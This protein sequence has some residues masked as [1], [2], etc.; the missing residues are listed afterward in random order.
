M[1]SS[2]A[3]CVDSQPARVFETIQQRDDVGGRGRLRIIPQP[4]E[5]GAA[6]LRIDREQSRERVPLRIGHARPRASRR[7]S[8]APVHGRPTRFAPAPPP[9]EAERR[10]PADGR[11]SPGRWVR[12]DPWPMPRPCQPEDRCA[13]RPNRSSAG[14]DIFAARPHVRGG[15]G[16][17]AR[18]RRTAPDR[19]AESDRATK[20]IIG[21]RRLLGRSHAE[22]RIAKERK[23]GRRSRAG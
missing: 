12:R 14:T 3:R 8:F 22:A 23:A 18:S 21:L 10:S 1:D 2:G 20:A 5:A 9:P 15:S 6:Q 16:P 13:S 4:G 11:A 19:H 17:A 7:S